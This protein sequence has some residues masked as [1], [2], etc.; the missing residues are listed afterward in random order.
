MTDWEPPKRLFCPLGF[1]VLLRSGLLEEIAGV[2]LS[3]A[4]QACKLSTHSEWQC[5]PSL[6]RV[7][8]SVLDQLMMQKCKKTIEEEEEMTEWINVEVLEGW[9]ILV[10]KGGDTKRYHDALMKDECVL[11]VE[12]AIADFR[13]QHGIDGRALTVYVIGALHEGFDEKD[14]DGDPCYPS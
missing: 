13:V 4:H 9:E 5:G 2:S 11:V 14:N 3:M 7:F 8:E 1:R 12:H 10:K 6:Q